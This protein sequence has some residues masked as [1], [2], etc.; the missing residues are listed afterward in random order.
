[1]GYYTDVKNAP[2]LRQGLL[3]KKFDVALLNAQLV[4][5]QL[6][7]FTLKVSQHAVI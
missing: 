1:V 6:Q 7:Q 2:A 4:C 5:W 3:D